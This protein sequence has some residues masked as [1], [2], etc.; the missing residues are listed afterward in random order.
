MHEHTYNITI[1]LGPTAGNV[2]LKTDYIE[3]FTVNATAGQAITK[4]FP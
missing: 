1:H 3:I 2:S 4:N